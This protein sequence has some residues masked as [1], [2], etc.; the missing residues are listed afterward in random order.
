MGPMVS[1]YFFFG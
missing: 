1:F